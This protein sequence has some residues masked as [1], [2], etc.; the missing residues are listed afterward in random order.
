M[1]RRAD[2]GPDGDVA[3]LDINTQSVKAG[4]RLG[5]K[6]TLVLGVGKPTWRER[7]HGHLPWPKG[8]AAQHFAPPGNRRGEGERLRWTSTW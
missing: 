1:T 5:V 4:A 3:R 2:A 6:Q 8:G 7:H